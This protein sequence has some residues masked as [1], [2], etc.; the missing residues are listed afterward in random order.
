MEQHQSD[1]S[2]ARPSQAS[3]AHDRSE[4][5]E[6]Q[7]YADEVARLRHTVS[8]GET[9]DLARRRELL[10]ALRTLVREHAQ[11]LL[12]AV[13]ADVGKPVLEVQMT[14]LAQVI[15]EID[16]QL[17]HLQSWTADRAVGVPST[18]LPASA[19]EQLQPKGV[20]LVIS[21]WNYPVQL[22][23]SPLA[24]VLAA[25]NTALLKPSEFAPR[26][27]S[28][29]TELIGRYLPADI[30]SVVNG[31]VPETT[32]LLRERFDHIV[33]TGSTAVARVI[34]RAAAEHLTPVTLELGGK[35]PTFVDDSVDLRAAARRIAWGKFN[36]AGQTCIAPD[37]VLVT[38]SAREEFLAAMAE[39]ITEFYGADPQGSS[40]F[41]RIVNER[42][43]ARLVELLEASAGTL[44]AGGEHDL[45][46]RCYLAPTVVADVEGDDSLMSQELFGP[47]LPVLTV[48]DHHEA[49]AQIGGRAR[50][51]ALYVF[52]EDPQVRADFET[53]TI[54]GAL[55]HGAAL[56]HLAVPGLPFGGTGDSGIGRYLGRASI[57]E[58]SHHRSVLSKPVS[59]DTLSAIYP[60]LT[61]WK[62]TMVRRLMA[63]LS[64]NVLNKAVP[65]RVISG[66]RRLPGI[67]TP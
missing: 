13:H 20:I 11:E 1:A 6:G 5:A 57:E 62:R 51:L 9:L 29:L 25:G 39:T 42:Q 53:S 56:L 2:H 26:T 61:R 64:R 63:P 44:V 50:P 60:P 15:K 41:G 40:D 18:L 32:A 36:N 30:V 31:G 48:A 33:F 3:A 28:L 55:V 21:P 19:K 67:R 52:T 10:T 4:A 17:D 46:D 8:S 45:A 7:F 59:P 43:H 66:A 23:L 65:V 35:S 58:F 16:E 47:I 22:L 37:H 24:G 38:A 34:M 54:S 49:I 14:E 27:A 12:E